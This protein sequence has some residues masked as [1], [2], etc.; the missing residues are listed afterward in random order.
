M[1]FKSFLFLLIFALHFFPVFGQK[2]IGGKVLESG[3]NTPISY[4]NIGIINSR[5]GTISNKDGSFSIDIPESNFNDSLTF[6]ALGFAT[7]TI[8][9]KKLTENTGNPI[10]LKLKE[11]QLG[12]V[13]VLSKSNKVKEYDLGNRYFKE[14]LNMSSAE[15]ATAGA[16][17][18]LLIENKYPSFHEELKYP[19]YLGEAKVRISDNTTGPFKIRVRLLEVDS[20]TGYPGKDLFDQSLVLESD[21][22]KGW[23]GFDFSDYKLQVKGPFFLAFEWIMEEQERKELKEIYRDFEAN[24]P[25]RVVMDTVMVDGKEIVN[26]H[27]IKF[28]PGTAF[29][30][31]LL[32]FSLD[33][34]KCYSLYNSLGEWQR[35]AYILSARVT[36][37][38]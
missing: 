20:M 23:L 2:T 8:P 28:L 35:A 14:G 7:Q 15:D 34:Y 26:R 10:Y 19:V 25:E 11:T 18:A 31:S 6:F 37:W 16:S 38:N 22:E 12:E 4:A 32:P 3:T 13:T 36:V 24:Y 17:V 21:M 5:V 29:G 33:N 27:Y 9:L 1:N 30:V